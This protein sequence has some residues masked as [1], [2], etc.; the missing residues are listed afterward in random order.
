MTVTS[1]PRSKS[2]A[3]T[4][5]SSS[6]RFMGLALWPCEMTTVS[7]LAILDFGFLILDWNRKSKIENVLLAFVDLP[8]DGPL[9]DGPTGGQMDEIIL[10]RQQPLT[11]AFHGEQPA[12]AVWVYVNARGVGEQVL[13]ELHQPAGHWRVEFAFGLRAFDGADGL[14]LAQRRRRVDRPLQKVH[15]LQQADG[16][17]REAEAKSVP[18]CRR[19]GPHVVLCIAAIDGEPGGKLA[20]HED[21]LFA[22]VY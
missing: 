2:K 12:L 1:K 11:G 16:V 5:S 20:H 22:H 17:G 7:F 19:F 13:V 10:G 8:F 3:P 6:L 4:R 21:Q 15:V 9:G 14:L 18:L